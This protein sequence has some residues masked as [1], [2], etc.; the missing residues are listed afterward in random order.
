MTTYPKATA[1]ALE[2]SI[3]YAQG[4]I[5]S[6]QVTKNSVGNITLFAFDKGQ[7][8]TEHTADY[9]AFVQILDGEAEIR[10]GDCIIMPAKVPHALRATESFKML[11]TMIRGE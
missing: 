7:G 2:S 6:K 3:E 1:I 11:L 8:L 4:A 10:I 9:D 5:I